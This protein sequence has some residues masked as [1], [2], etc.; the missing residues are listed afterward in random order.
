MSFYL[1]V[2]VYSNTVYSWHRAC[3]QDGDC[4]SKLPWTTAR[5]LIFRGQAIGV[6]MCSIVQLLFKYLDSPL[7][8]VP[9]NCRACNQSSYSCT[10]AAELDCID[11]MLHRVRRARPMTPDSPILYGP[12]ARCPHSE[13]CA[14]PARAAR[15]ARWWPRRRCRG[16]RWRSAAPGRT[17]ATAAAC[18]PAPTRRRCA[19]AAG[20]LYMQAM[21]AC[22]RRLNVGNVS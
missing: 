3:M 4:M 17:P 16:S 10:R 1:L 14:A 8:G 2:H 9:Q 15:P 21:P 11:M 7:T 5:K 18:A 20:A 19:A 12:V 22:R 6:Q 13:T